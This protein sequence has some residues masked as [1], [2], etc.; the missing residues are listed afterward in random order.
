MGFLIISR[1][2]YKIP[3]SLILIMK[4][5]IVED[6]RPFEEALRG[7]LRISVVVPTLEALVP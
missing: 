1:L 3:H 5:P 2:S 6:S 7:L 4:A